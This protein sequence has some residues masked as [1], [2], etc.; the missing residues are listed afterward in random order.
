MGLFS[1]LVLPYLKNPTKQ[2]TVKLD[3]WRFHKWLA[4]VLSSIASLHKNGF[5]S[6]NLQ[7]KPAMNL[8]PWL[9]ESLVYIVLKFITI[10]QLPPKIWPQKG[11]KI[12]QK[13]I[14]SPQSG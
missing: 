11:P 6:E 4:K 2:T 5:G 1:K 10:S 14:K 8:L 3:N 12:L 13:L 7:H 9:Q